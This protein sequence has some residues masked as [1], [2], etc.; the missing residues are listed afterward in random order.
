MKPE[1]IPPIVNDSGDESHPAF[2]FISAHRVSSTPGATL[3]DSDIQHSHFMRVTL[4]RATRKRD[5]NRDWLHPTSELIEVDM[6][7]A[8]W[9]AFVSSTNTS[10][11]PCT[12]SWLTGEGQVPG[13]IPAPRLHKSITEVQNAADKAFAQVK[14]AYAA[15]EA[16]PSNAGVKARREAMSRVKWAIENAPKNISYAADTLTEHT[17]N[18]VQRARADIEAMVVQKAE[19]MGLDSSGV[20]VPA[21]TANPEPVQRDE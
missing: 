11:V 10:G 4:S 7:E 17:E 20:M 19:Q 3:F 9:A 6:S 18:V 13:L 1:P 8:Q 2:G 16:L 21:L 14:E 5:L 12:L 15:L